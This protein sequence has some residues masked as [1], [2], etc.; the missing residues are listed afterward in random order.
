MANKKTTRVSK[1]PWGKFETL[2]D[3]PNYKVKRLTVVPKGKLSLQSHN[4]RSE[5]WVIAHGVAK[6]TNGKKE[7]TLKKSEH[8]FI[9]VGN[10]HRLEN[11]G[12]E[13]LEVIEIQT[14]DYFGEDD[15]IR[16]ADIYNRV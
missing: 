16:Y 1:R 15:I 8:I 7:I 4:H 9:P 3:A 14:G 6:I 11:L 5:N 2:I 10:K 13:N 12:K